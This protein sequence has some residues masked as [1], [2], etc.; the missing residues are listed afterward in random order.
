[1]VA[2]FAAAAAEFLGTGTSDAEQAARQF[3]AWLEPGP[4]RPSC[5]WLIVLDVADPADLTGLWPPASSQG[6]T[7]VTSRRRDAAIT[8]GRRIVPVGVFTPADSQSYLTGALAAADRQETDTELA[9]LADDLGHLPL[10]LSQAAAYLIDTGL[11]C[12]TYR[13]LLADRARTLAEAAPDRLPDDQPHTVAAAWDLSIE[14]ADSLHPPGLARPV[15]RLAV[16]LSPSGIPEA[17]LNS[18]P[19]L[20][21]LSADRTPTPECAP[22]TQR[23]VA[24]STRGSS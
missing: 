5:R 12:S 22:G 3:L 23:P 6:R 15:L 21:H 19:V 10:A 14:R 8:M 20:A 18:P 7:L 1:M 16:F 13:A 17:V 4:G 11:P 9:A 24:R 2:G